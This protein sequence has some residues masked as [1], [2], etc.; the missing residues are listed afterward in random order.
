[1]MFKHG[2][3]TVVLTQTQHPASGMAKNASGLEHHL[4]HDRFDA[5]AFCRMPHG[6]VGDVH[7]MLTNQ[8]QQVHGHRGELA[9]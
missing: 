7:R 2:K 4:L 6:R 3:S 9:H 5:P 8:A 1:M